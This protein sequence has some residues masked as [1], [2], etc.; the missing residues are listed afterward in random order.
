MDLV[1]TTE[2]NSACRPDHVRHPAVLRNI[3]PVYDRN[4]DVCDAGP[5]EVR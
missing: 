1:S 2:K 3:P 4:F 5:V